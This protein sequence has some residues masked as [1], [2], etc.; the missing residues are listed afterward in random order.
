VH[1]EQAN[2]ASAVQGIL[3]TVAYAGGSFHGFVLQA[4]GRTVAQELLGAV[5]KRDPHVGAFRCVSRTDAGVHARGQLVAFD[6]TRVISPRGW[7]LAVNQ[8]LPDEVSVRHA[9]VVAVGFDPRRHV[10]QK[11]YRYSLHL[12]VRRDPFLEP[13]GWRIHHPLDLDLA[14]GDAA[15]LVGTHDFA[16][17]RSAADQRE[18]TVRTISRVLIHQDADDPRV[19]YVDVCGTGFLHNMVRIIVGTLYDIARGHLPPGTIRKALATGDR[20]DLGITAPSQGLCLM[21]VELESLAMIGP[22][23]PTC[24][25]PGMSS[26]PPGCEPGPWGRNHLQSDTEDP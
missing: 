7:V 19:A 25:L 3:L 21:K 4:N 11:W 10:K 9:A 23:W 16:A 24:S 22:G 8:D 20:R 6:M 17:F 2:R 5:Q 26:P 15:D 12:D 18:C 1:Q 13:F 14:R